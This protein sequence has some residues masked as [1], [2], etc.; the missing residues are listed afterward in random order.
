MSGL[1]I[2]LPPLYDNP[3]FYGIAYTR[4]D[5]TVDCDLPV[6]RGRFLV[7]I[8]IYLPAQYDK[9][10]II[11][12]RYFWSTH[13]CEDTFHMKIIKSRYRRRLTDE[14][15]KYCLHFWLSNYKHSEQYVTARF[16]EWLWY[17]FLIW[18]DT[19]FI[20]ETIVFMCLNSSCCCYFSSPS[21]PNMCIYIYIYIYIYIQ[22]V[23]GGTDQTSGGCSLC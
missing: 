14:H 8:K 1:C 13:I 15:L 3:A 21:R 2:P 12:Q 18:E 7:S 6:D 23:T 10:V 17:I 19:F 22:G 4:C 16:A 20:N 11:L 5:W 9:Y